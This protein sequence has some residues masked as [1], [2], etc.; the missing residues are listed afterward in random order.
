[1]TTREL[2]AT[3]ASGIVFS[4]DAVR[5]IREGRKTQFS[6]PL[7]DEIQRYQPSHLPSHAVGYPSHWRIIGD[8]D[9]GR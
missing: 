3:C 8:G 4:D 2:V 7:P 9:N 6:R 5:S 1:M